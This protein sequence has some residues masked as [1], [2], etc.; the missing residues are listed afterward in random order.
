MAAPDDLDNTQADDGFEFTLMPFDA[1]I[2]LDD[3]ATTERGM[4]NLLRIMDLESD[5]WASMYASDS[6]WDE[7]WAAVVAWCGHAF[8]KGTEGLLQ[9]RLLVLHQAESDDEAQR[10]YAKLDRDIAESVKAG[11]GG[12]CGRQ[13]RRVLRKHYPAGFDRPSVGVK[14]R[15]GDVQFMLREKT[16]SQGYEVIRVSF[17]AHEKIVSEKAREKADSADAARGQ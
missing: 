14:K 17:D 15:E 12:I 9:L 16:R 3:N 10:Q 1:A 8:E 2:L 6:E 13:A 5:E 11:E 4:A 7:I